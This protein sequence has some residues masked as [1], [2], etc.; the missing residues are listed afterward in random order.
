MRKPYKK[1]LAFGE[2]STPEVALDKRYDRRRH[3]A[4]H[5]SAF[6]FNQ[7]IPYIGNK[8]KLLDLI[9]KALEHT[10]PRDSLTFLDIFAG[11]GVVS[12]LA[13]TLGYQVIANDWEPYTRPINTCYI[14]CNRPPALTAL[15]G[16]QQAIARL[17]SLP[18]RVDW[19]TE[20]LCPRDDDNYNTEVDRMFYM[21]KNGMRIDAMRHQI[22]AWQADGVI[23][24]TEASCLL[25]PLLYQVCYRSNTSGVFKAFHKGWGG[26]T[27]TALYRIATDLQLSPAVFFDNGKNN[28]VVCQDAQKLA[29]ELAAQ[30]LDV[31]Y[32]DPPYNQHPYASNYH[33]LNTVALWDKPLL[34]KHI[35]KGTKS[36]IRT[37]WRTER[38]SA[39]N[40]RGEATQAYRKLLDTLNARYLLTSYSTDGTILLDQM[41]LANAERGHVHIEMRA[42]KRYRVSSQ[43]FSRKPVNVEFIIVLDTHRHSDVSPDQLREAIKATEQEALHKHREYATEKHEQLMLFEG[44]RE[45]G[46]ETSTQKSPQR[47]GH[48]CHLKESRDRDDPSLNQG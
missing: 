8:R 25:G 5:T 21:R 1:Y 38:R 45:Y 3:A 48:Q 46:Q 33:V 20:H 15:G 36:A 42:Y 11:S 16:Y 4:A 26:Q 44:A 29:A 34:A 47:H 32:L 24:E 39:Y 22:E 14:G 31:V 17:N 10:E 19:I 7:L 13:K 9:Q 23:N 37:G 6:V 27:Q 18:P 30:E 35:T 41:L 28:R 12:R 43:R 40:Y 2:I